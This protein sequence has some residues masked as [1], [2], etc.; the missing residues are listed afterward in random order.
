MWWHLSLIMFYTIFRHMKGKYQSPRYNEFDV[1]RWAYLMSHYSVHT[2]SFEYIQFVIPWLLFC[3]LWIRSPQIII[4]DRVF[5][6]YFLSSQRDCQ[7]WVFLLIGGRWLFGKMS[8]SAIASLISVK[9]KGDHLILAN[10]ALNVAINVNILSIA[11]SLLLKISKL[12]RSFLDQIKLKF[13]RD[14][15]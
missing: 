13:F 10:L 8:Y 5:S 1:C 12:H 14:N 11:G 7:L 15:R 3:T 6:S 2:N 4:C 9:V